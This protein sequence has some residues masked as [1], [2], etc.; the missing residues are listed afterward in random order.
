M[1]GLSGARVTITLGDYDGM[2]LNEDVWTSVGEK[3]LS[4]EMEQNHSRTSKIKPV[5]QLDY[6]FLGDCSD[7]SQVQ[8]LTAIDLLSV[9]GLSCFV[10]STGRSAYSQAELRRF[11]LETGRTFGIFQI[12][13]EPALK[14][15]VSE[16]TS[17][18]DGLAVRHSPTGWK[19]AQRAV[20]PL[21]LCSRTCT[22][23]FAL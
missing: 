18:V 10:P 14:A 16:V 6:A 4:V 22:R 23:R 5:I 19:Q 11:I 8:L 2:V 20:G 7:D 17:E 1:S 13:P 9:L 21:A 12:D 15:L 3:P